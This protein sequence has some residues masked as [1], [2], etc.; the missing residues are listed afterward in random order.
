MICCG[1]QIT[2][3]AAHARRLN[4]RDTVNLKGAIPGSGFG[5]GTLGGPGTQYDANSNAAETNAWRA[6][7]Q[8]R[9]ATRLPTVAGLDAAPTGFAPQ[10]GSMMAPPMLVPLPARG[11]PMQMPRA[12]SIDFV[13]PAIPR[14]TSL[15]DMD[16]RLVDQLGIA[17]QEKGKLDQMKIFV[18]SQQQAGVIKKDRVTKLLTKLVALLGVEAVVAA[19]NAVVG[20]TD[21]ESML[22]KTLKDRLTPSQRI[23]LDQFMSLHSSHGPMDHIK[24]MQAQVNQDVVVQSLC[25]VRTIRKLHDCGSPCTTHD[26]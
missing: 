7:L 14:S 26:F 11:P 24:F 1:S 6:K 17:L 20:S 5:S 19:T 4:S 8:Q 12:D 21:V 3:E 9:N 15:G 18:Q 2:A 13:S 25:E 23:S 16:A 22:L 10:A